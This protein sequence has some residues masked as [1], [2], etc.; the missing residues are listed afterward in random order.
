MSLPAGRRG[1]ER[2]TVA[3][4]LDCFKASLSYAP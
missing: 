3:M 1:G 2:L 4:D